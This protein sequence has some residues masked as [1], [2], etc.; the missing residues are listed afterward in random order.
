MVVRL[1]LALIAVAT[2]TASFTSITEFAVAHGAHLQATYAIPLALEPLAVLAGW[3]YI[4]RRDRSALAVL[5][6]AFA[7]AVA[8]NVADA[9]PSR[10]LMALYAIPPIA[11][12]C[13][14]HV[15]QRSVDA[16]AHAHA[17][18]RAQA[19]IERT[20]RVMETTDSVTV[21]LEDLRDDVRPIVAAHLDAG[22]APDDPQLTLRVQDELGVAKRTAQARLAP[23][24]NGHG[25]GS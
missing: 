6:L 20:T 8:I 15:L 2:L 17:D 21:G 9:Y 10:S 11:V 4:R 18:H 1:G 7:D 16:D 22:G 25:G 12:M 3:E 23:L 13:A 19:R 5:W 14:T 24:G